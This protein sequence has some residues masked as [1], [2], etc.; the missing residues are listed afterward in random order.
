MHK[1]GR[2]TEL[3]APARDY[4]AAR[5]AVDFG[6]DAIYAGGPAFGARAG[7]CNS[8]EDIAR[9]ADY[10]RPYGVRVYVALNTL[11]FPGE[12]DEARDV[13][14]RM[15][16]AGADALIVQDMAYLRMGLEGVELHASTQTQNSTPER[17]AFLERCGFSRVILE[18]GLSLRQ[19]EEIRAATTVGLEAFVHGAICVCR[20][21]RCYMSRSMGSRS[22][23]R[24]DCSQPCRLPWDLIDGA[25][26]VHI[27]GKHL[28]SLRDLNLSRHIPAMLA[29]GIDSF[30]I[31]G[32]LKDALYVKNVVAF[33]RAAMDA[34]MGS[35]M[36][37]ASAGVSR[38]D[39]VPD[40]SKSFSRG[41]T[42]YYFSGRSRGA[43]S[44]DTPK[45]A[46]EVMGRVVSAGRRDFFLDRH[47]DLS[48]GDG[49]CLADGSSG[50]GVNA[51]DGRRITPNVM[52]GI[53]PGAEI[54]RNRDHSF[55]ADL[56]RSRTR[57]VIEAQ[58]RVEVGPD[59]ITLVLDDGCGRR[60]EARAEGGFDPAR[61]AEKMLQTIKTQTCRSGDTPLAIT[62]ADVAAAG[63]VPFVPL[64][65]LNA[66]RRSAA[67]ALLAIPLPRPESVPRAE[68]PAKMPA[69][70]GGGY[71]NITNPLAEKFHLD[72]GATDMVPGWDLA[73]GMKGVEVMSTPYCIRRETGQCLRGRHTLAGPL[74]IEHGRHRYAL[75][76]DC[77]N[78]EMKIICQ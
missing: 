52:D 46:G 53:R 11:L 33:Y 19:M 34:A 5:A 66:L 75:E 67:E 61:D 78:C 8:A 69:G 24:G 2:I 25:G 12:T 23:N 64:S 54:L 56:T 42:P 15:I 32:R 41:F 14:V 47:S 28:L 36:R 18:R 30:K 21:G 49:I 20:S 29:A 44:F 73:A 27:K 50:T 1:P 57:R 26:K 10:A 74:F 55:E 77:E 43:A 7:A 65:Q 38:P 45:A 39:F 76:F 17:V 71:A 4:D 35:D 63:G 48:P 13:A 16:A 9:M 68:L 72:H 37:R 22:G 62:R 3:L 51:V 6:A 58:A 59:S 31:E 40:P 60:A 70:L